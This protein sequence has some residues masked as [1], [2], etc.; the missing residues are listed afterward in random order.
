MIVVLDGLIGL[1]AL[2]SSAVW[3]LA[4]RQRLRRISRL[5]E[6][7][8]A[9]MNRLVTV[10]NRT[11]ILNARAALLASVTAAL[12]ALRIGIQAVRDV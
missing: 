1:C 4:S 3:W 11:Q 6:L 7:D 5:E 8:A 12:A 9:D 10:L 2:A